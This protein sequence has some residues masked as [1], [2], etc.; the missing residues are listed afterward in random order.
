MSLYDSSSE[1]KIVLTFYM[2]CCM[3]RVEVMQICQFFA[4]MQKDEF[5]KT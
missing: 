1:D 2:L 5:L 3:K 4:R